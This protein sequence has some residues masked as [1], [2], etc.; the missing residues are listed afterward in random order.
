VNFTA[1]QN[2]DFATSKGIEL[3]LEL[4]RTNRLSA[5]VNYTLSDARGTGNSSA[6]N[7]VAVGDESRAR[8]PSFT[9]PLS[10]NQTHRGNVTLDYRY[11]KGEGGPILASWSPTRETPTERSA[12]R[13]GDKLQKGRHLR[14][15]E[16]PGSSSVDTLKCGQHRPFLALELASTREEEAGSRL[17]DEETESPRGENAKRA[18][19]AGGA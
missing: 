15:G 9:A 3:T 1:F 7:S 6:S 19:T 18:T 14:E 5:K 4:R 2:E 11:A 10:Y 8:F 17:Y 13:R 12:L 16:T